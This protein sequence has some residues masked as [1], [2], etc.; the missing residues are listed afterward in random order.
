MPNKANQETPENNNPETI[1]T[2]ILSDGQGAA[3]PEQEQ[4]DY[5]VIIA[6]LNDKLL[7][8]AAEMQNI[9]RR[10]DMDI[11]K[12][13]HF[14]IESFARDLLGVMDNLCRAADSISNE[15]AATDARLKTIKDGVEITKKELSNVFERHHMKKVGAIGDKY[16][17]NLHQAMVQ[18]EDKEKEPGTIVHVMQDGYVVRDRLLRPALVTI[19][20]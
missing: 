9:R 6:E 11:Q 13:K 7:R 17:H 5:A 4:S 3:A 18:I 16:D 14:S 15:D 19:T 20:K 10:S 1:E 2:E 12:A 8:S